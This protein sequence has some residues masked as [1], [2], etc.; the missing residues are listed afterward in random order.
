MKK[1]TL[2]LL[3]CVVSLTSTNATI[4]S[5]PSE[6][7]NPATYVNDDLAKILKANMNAFVKMTPREYYKLTG[8]KLTL[9]ETLKLKAAQKI[10]KKKMMGGEG[11]TKGVYI[12]LAILGL[13][14]IAMGVKDDWSGNNWWV[15]LILTALCLLPGFIHAL[16]KMKEYYK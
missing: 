3:F 13:A 12:L 1:V 8:K 6:T 5:V 2:I 15:N 7:P 11:M 16:V 10:V 9:G 4:P 14:W